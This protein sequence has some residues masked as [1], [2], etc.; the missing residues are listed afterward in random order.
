MFIPP[1][2]FMMIVSEEEEKIMRKFYFLMPYSFFSSIKASDGK[3]IPADS[4]A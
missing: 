2:D 4:R 1:S 3:R